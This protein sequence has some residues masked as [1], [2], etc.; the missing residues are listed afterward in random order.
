MTIEANVALARRFLEDAYSDGRLDLLP[1]LLAPS[2]ADRDAPPGYSQDRDG[3]RQLMQDFRTAFPDLRFTV[4]DSVA[5]EDRVVLRYVVT[6]THRGTFMG[7]PP[8]G[9]SFKINGISE[10]RVADGKLQEAWVQYD[11]LGMLRQ[12]GALPDPTA[13]PA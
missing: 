11:A 9:R 5:Q 2:Y 12:L 10:Y 1:Q 7:M 6:G 13:A 4:L 3:V 8:S